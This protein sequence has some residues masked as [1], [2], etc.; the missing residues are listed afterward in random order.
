MKP[1]ALWRN[2]RYNRLTRQPIPGQDSLVF[3]VM[4]AN[5]RRNWLYLDGRGYSINIIGSKAA[6]KICLLESRWSFPWF[7]Y[8]WSWVQREKD[9]ISLRVWSKKSEN[10]ISVSFILHTMSASLLASSLTTSSLRLVISLKNYSA[11]L[12]VLTRLSKCKKAVAPSK[13]H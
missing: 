10:L 7:E 8:F 11:N 3:Q 13:T 5:R 4:S 1:A 2:Y 12:I 6:V 9:K